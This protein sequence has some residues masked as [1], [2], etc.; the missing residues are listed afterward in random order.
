VQGKR[1]SAAGVLQVLAFT[2][3]IDADARDALLIDGVILVKTRLHS[4]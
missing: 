3:V 2:A 4:T 1:A